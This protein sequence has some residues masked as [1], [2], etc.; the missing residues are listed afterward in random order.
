MEKD[1]TSFL[2]RAGR[3]LLDLLEKYISGIAFST[4]FLVFVI[5]VFFR[6][7]LN[8][9]LIWPYEVTIFA[10]IWTTVL[11]ACYAKRDNAHVVFSL[12][13][14]G[15]TPLVQLIFRVVGNLLIVT[16][17]VIAFGPTVRYI[18]FQRINRTAALGIPFYVGFGPYLIFMVLIAGRVGYDLW[19]DLRSLVRGAPR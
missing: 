8:N 1:R 18:E 9:P 7:V 11:G 13:Y 15:Q 10:F 16:S 14:D 3:V 19:V 12:V 6:Y 17:M 2:S 5:Q 4:L